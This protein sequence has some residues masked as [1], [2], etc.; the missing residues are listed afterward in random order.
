MNSDEN[1]IETHSKV[2]IGKKTA[3]RGPLSRVVAS[4]AK[5][6]LSIET[7]E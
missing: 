4:S 3:L 2:S 5:V 6:F 1:S 7:L